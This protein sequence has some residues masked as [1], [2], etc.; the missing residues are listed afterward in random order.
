MEQIRQQLDFLMGENRNEDKKYTEIKH[1]TD[2]R[3]CKYDIW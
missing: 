1:F 3:V 2:Q